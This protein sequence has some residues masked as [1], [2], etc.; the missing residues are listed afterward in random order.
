[1]FLEILKFYNKS[2]KLNEFD[3]SI[4]LGEYLIK[5]KHSEYFI[6]YH[7][8]LWYLQ[9]GQCHHMMQKMPIKFFMR[10]FQNHGLFNLSNR[11]QWHYK[12]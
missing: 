10:F 3:E 8:I 1:M 5:E 11:P 7:L 12:K 9:F 4:S 6:N 2:S